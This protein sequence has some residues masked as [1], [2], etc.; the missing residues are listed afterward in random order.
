MPIAIVIPTYVRP[1][2]ATVHK[3][4]LLSQTNSKN[5]LVHLHVALF[6][7]LLNLLN[8]KLARTKMKCKKILLLGRVGVAFF[9]RVTPSSQLSIFY[10]WV[11]IFWVV[12]YCW[13][14]AQIIEPERPIRSTRIALDTVKLS[15]ICFQTKLIILHETSI[16]Y[17]K[18]RKVRFTPCNYNKS[19]ILNLQLRNRII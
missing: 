3:S 2:W 6:S 18:K 5:L 7:F 17:L 13:N 4:P 16:V 14:F 19:P 11:H 9:M 1:Y 15:F 8:K 10:S 12:F